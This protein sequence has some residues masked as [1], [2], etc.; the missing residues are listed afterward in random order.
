MRVCLSACQSV[1]LCDY[2]L[3][4]DA[5]PTVEEE[6]N[7]VAASLPVTRQFLLRSGVAVTHAHVLARTVS[8][9]QRRDL[10]SHTRGARGGGRLGLGERRRVTAAAQGP[11]RGRRGSA[12][13]RSL[14][15][16][17][18]ADAP[19]APRYI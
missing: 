16:G 12:P 3:Y 6:G 15:E 8:L 17:L 10:H 9:H 19:A 7:A 13:S 4:F 5:F 1:C 2:F 11:C 18:A 14:K